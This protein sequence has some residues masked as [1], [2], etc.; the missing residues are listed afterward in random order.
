M[1]SDYGIPRELSD[2]QKIRSHYEPDL[3][4]CLQVPLSPSLTYTSSNISGLIGIVVLFTGSLSMFSKKYGIRLLPRSA[5]VQKNWYWICC[6][7]PSLCFGSYLF[8]CYSIVQKALQLFF[9]FY[10]CRH[11]FGISDQML[12]FPPQTTVLLSD[13]KGEFW[14]KKILFLFGREHSECSFET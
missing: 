9:D 1:D 4:P 12:F 10:S 6:C 3:P 14:L 7:L 5:I 13:T 2:L 8:G 11:D